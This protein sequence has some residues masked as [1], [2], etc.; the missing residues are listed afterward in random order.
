MGGE[1][2]V[3]QSIPGKLLINLLAEYLKNGVLKA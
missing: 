2:R 3:G 1:V